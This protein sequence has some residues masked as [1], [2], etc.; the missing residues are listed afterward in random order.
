M[1]NKS[2]TYS[3][4]QLLDIVQLYNQLKFQFLLNKSYGQALLTRLNY[5]DQLTA[6]EVDELSM[7]VKISETMDTIEQILLGGVVT[8]IIERGRLAKI[9]AELGIAE[10]MTIWERLQP[11]YNTYV[12]VKAERGL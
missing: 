10:W 12:E 1:F 2:D 6:K 8:D 5:G 3:E 11:I 9:N 4:D 7:F